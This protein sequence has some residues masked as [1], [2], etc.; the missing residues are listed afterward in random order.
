MPRTLQRGPDYTLDVK[1]RVPTG[2]VDRT[3]QPDLIPYQDKG[4]SEGLG[5]IGGGLGL[6]GGLA[7]IGYNIN[8]FFNQNNQKNADKGWDDLVP[9]VQADYN[10]M[11]TKDLAEL[12]ELNTQTIKKYTEHINGLDYNQETKDKIISSLS[13]YAQREMEQIYSTGLAEDKVANINNLSATIETRLQDEDIGGAKRAIIEASEGEDAWLD[14]ESADI[15]ILQS[16]RKHV[17]TVAK[18]DL[19]EMDYRTAYDHITA[20]ILDENGEPTYANMTD[21]TEEDRTILEKNIVQQGNYEEQ[22]KS[23]ITQDAMN[24][25]LDSLYNNELTIADFFKGDIEGLDMTTKTQVVNTY[26]G[27][28]A[29]NAAKLSDAAAIPIWKRINDGDITDVATIQALNIKNLSEDERSRMIVRLRTGI[30][31]GKSPSDLQKEGSLALRKSLNTT[32]VNGMK[33]IDVLRAGLALTGEVDPSTNLMKLLASDYNI[34][35]KNVE[36]SSSMTKLTSIVSGAQRDP[37]FIDEETGEQDEEMFSQFTREYTELYF[38]QVH[39]IDPTK[40]MNTEQFAKMADNLIKTITN[41]SLQEKFREISRS[42]KNVSIGMGSSW[43]SN[44]MEDAVSSLNEGMYDAMEYI[45][46]D[47]WSLFRTKM[48]DQY[49]EIKGVKYDEKVR[50]YHNR[51]PIFKNEAGEDQMIIIE[52]KIP[53]LVSLEVGLSKHKNLA[54]GYSIGDRNAEN[55]TM[56]S[57]GWLEIDKTTVDEVGLVSNGQVIRPKGQDEM[58]ILYNSIRGTQLRSFH[59]DPTDRTQVAAAIKESLDPKIDKVEEENPEDVVKQKAQETA[60]YVFTPPVN[61]VFTPPVN[62]RNIYAIPGNQGN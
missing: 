1:T 17:F 7:K 55:E 16:E 41:E 51:I 32:A 61:H 62:L 4:L 28:M 2:Q 29:S 3:D 43:A 59:G 52:N 44:A 11:P 14:Q 60:P 50:W 6:L 48:I 35:K 37:R 9:T 58:Y 24:T 20:Q 39:E 25:S 46:P 34:V 56:L 26:E 45:D 54:L 49:E 15:M 10:L 27:Q 18:N 40:Q 13:D 53:Q 31:K 12:P 30:P 22:R 23:L 47:S 8:D 19:A 36:D 42:E 57:S 5:L 21:L 38:D 33:A